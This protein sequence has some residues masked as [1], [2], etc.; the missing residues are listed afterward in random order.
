M[1]CC[2]GVFFPEELNN[3]ARITSRTVDELAPGATAFAAQFGARF[4]F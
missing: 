2:A 1:F 4:Q 3:A